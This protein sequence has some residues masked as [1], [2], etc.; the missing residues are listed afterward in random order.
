MDD[1]QKLNDS[2]LLARFVSDSCQRSF[3]TLVKRY[4]GL[5][6][7]AAARALDCSANIP[8]VGQQVFTQLAKSA[9]KLVPRNNLAGWLYQTATQKAWN[10][11]R[12]ERRA[13]S[14][15]QKFQLETMDQE[16]KSSRLW[17]E[18]SPVV[19]T[20]LKGLP[21][22]DQDLILK[23]YFAGYS[24][25]ELAKHLN[26]SD[27]VI[28]KRLQRA[29]EKLK[30]RLTKQKGVTTSALIAAL[31]LGG[32]K[33][34]RAAVPVADQ[35]SRC[36]SLLNVTNLSSPGVV[37]RL[38]AKLG[39][40]SGLTVL[41]VSLPVFLAGVLVFTKNSRG[42]IE[43][44]QIE[45]VSS[46]RGKIRERMADGSTSNEK[47]RTWIRGTVRHIETNKPVAG[48]KVSLHLAEPV[49]PESAIDLDAPL[50]TLEA[51]SDSNGFYEI[52]V[53]G[54]YQ[55]RK[56]SMQLWKKGFSS[57]E[58][59]VDVRQEGAWER[60][61]QNFSHFSSGLEKEALSPDDEWEVDF[62]IVPEVEISGV[63][64]DEAGN[65]LK[66]AKVGYTFWQES[67]GKG[68]Q[69]SCDKEG[70]FTLPL[71]RLEEKHG[72]FSLNVSHE[73]FQPWEQKMVDGE[74]FQASGELQI[75]L[76][77]LDS[78]LISGRLIDSNGQAVPQGPVVFHSLQVGGVEVDG[79]PLYSHSNND[80]AFI[81]STEQLGSYQVEA[82][83]YETYESFSER[84][85]LASMR[86]DLIIQL[87]ALPEAPQEIFE[88]GG[89]QFQTITPKQGGS[90][91]YA[92][93]GAFI[94]LDVKKLAFH[95]NNL[96]SQNRADEQVEK[97]VGTVVL[98]PVPV[99]SPYSTEI[100]RNNPHGKGGPF[101]DEV[102]EP[103]NQKWFFSELR[104]H[105]KIFPD[106]SG[107]ITLVSVLKSGNG[108]TTYKL[109][110]NKNEV[111]EILAREG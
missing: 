19:D 81:V 111:A 59:K 87:E 68:S 73:N 44:P 107:R 80:G 52:P 4:A 43:E 28:R 89:F 37:R 105:L 67:S 100:T 27:A 6:H 23:R 56:M 3:S 84:L 96:Q 16:E 18:I 41:G 29:M 71:A 48:G 25:C 55:A 92:Q 10:W 49:Q 11:N 91:S 74:M 76:E 2:E 65:R 38:F 98:G 45:G 12:G 31:A 47:I 17:G 21:M 46:Y 50:K 88:V 69:T 15:H 9:P 58:M 8:D 99:D 13:Y 40:A 106:G 26:L 20:A 83:N 34:A 54:L 5:V 7:G 57:S 33:S 110:L 94:V 75:I 14:T 72:S 53:K 77:R 103:R 101:N 82:F 79:N 42:K 85:D 22:K 61:T 32:G 60:G 108:M 39:Q 70:R 36:G 51:F 104:R 30:S 78:H 1:F 66:G 95:F 90:F 93:N 62:T 97:L 63:V 109:S 35:W 86:D 64:Q 24:T 102:V